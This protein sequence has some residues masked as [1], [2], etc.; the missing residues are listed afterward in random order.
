[1][2]P[3]SRIIIDTDPGVDDVIAML[4]AFNANLEQL[5]VIC[6]WNALAV[7]HVVEKEIE[8]YESVNPAAY[9][10]FFMASKIPAYKEMLRILRENPPDTI[11]ILA[12]GPLT[13]VALAAAE[14]PETFLKVKEV[15]VMGG[16]INVP[17]NVTPAAEFN[18]ASFHHAT[19]I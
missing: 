3:K 17:G 13:N 5:E 14:N 6:L 16:A 4:L 1:M 15:V 19:S 11:S 10:S 7:F 2:T 12:M 9:S 18:T 8:W